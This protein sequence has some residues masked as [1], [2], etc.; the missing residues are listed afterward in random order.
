MKEKKSEVQ[1]ISIFQ[2]DEYNQQLILK[3]L[4]GKK[5]KSKIIKPSIYTFLRELKNKGII[6]SPKKERQVNKPHARKYFKNVDL[7]N[8]QEINK[9]KIELLFKIKHD[10]EFK[11]KKG[12]IKSLE[13]LEFKDLEQ[14]IYTTKIQT[15]DIN[16]INEYLDKLEGFFNAFENDINI[17]ENRKKEEERINGF[18]ND[19]IYKMDFAEILREKKERVF[20]SVIDFINI[21]HINE[22]SDLENVNKKENEKELKK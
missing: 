3:K 6:S 19:L 8:L 13:N 12:D 18:R 10:L 2:Q 21:N 22:L 9:R 15:F 14:K 4:R 16:G 5:R 1:D 20:G 7:K 17:A 11:I